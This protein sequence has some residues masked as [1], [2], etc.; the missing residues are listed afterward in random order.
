M[1]HFFSIFSL[2]LLSHVVV[3]AQ[4]VP[5][6]EI[7]PLDGE[8]NESAQEKGVGKKEEEKTTL[9]NLP[10]EGVHECT[11]RRPHGKKSR[12]YVRLLY[13]YH[14]VMEK[15]DS[16]GDGRLSDQE[17]ETIKMDEKKF[18]AERHQE[19]LAKFDLNKN[20][21]LDEEEKSTMHA[22]AKQKMVRRLEMK[23][24]HHF[25]KEAKEDKDGKGARLD[26]KECDHKKGERGH[27]DE[28]QNLSLPEPPS[29]GAPCSLPPPCLKEEGINPFPPLGSPSSHSLQKSRAKLLSPT[30]KMIMM[31]GH[32]LMMEKFDIDGDKDLSPDEFERM[33]KNRREFHRELRKKMMPLREKEHKSSSENK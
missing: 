32:H 7:L 28:G 22:E 14:L 17:L 33:Q 16:D 15:Y 9:K 4:L 13:F 31:L 30:E 29:L 5:P 20:G 19:I 6:V 2:A 10:Q 1:K 26:N 8:R 23:K 11:E 25:D 18:R 3:L 24:H 27:D 21:K 12:D